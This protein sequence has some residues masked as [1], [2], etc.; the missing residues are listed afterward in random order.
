MTAKISPLAAHNLARGEKTRCAVYL[1][2]KKLGDGATILQIVAETGINR[3]SVGKA[4]REV[5]GG[6][7]PEGME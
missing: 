2:M 3:V 1:A 7:K 6:W 5:M 4:R